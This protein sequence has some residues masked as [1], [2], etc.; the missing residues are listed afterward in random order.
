MDVEQ[1]LDDLKTVVRDGEQLLKAGVSEVR[2]K[3]LTGMKTT[4]K[5]VRELP[6][7]TIGIMF[8]VGVLAGMLLTGAFTRGKEAEE[9]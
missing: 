7:Q 2:Q 3:A 5:T 1:F 9:E 4:D 6:Y 8:G